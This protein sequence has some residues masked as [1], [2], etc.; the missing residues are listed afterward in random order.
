MKK[1]FKDEELPLYELFINDDDETGTRRI[2]IVGDPAVEIKGLAFNNNDSNKLEY[3]KVVRI[4][5][6]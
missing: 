1:I 6:L 3:F 2:S 4:N 5:K